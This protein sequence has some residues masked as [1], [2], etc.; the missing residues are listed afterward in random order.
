MDIETAMKIVKE[1]GKILDENPVHNIQG[2]RALLLPYDKDT[3]K[4]ALKVNLT[5]VGTAEKRDKKTFRS[6]K[7]GF[8]QLASFLPDGVV[9][10]MFHVEDALDSGDVCHK[11][12]KYLAESEKAGNLILEQTAKLVEELDEFCQD[13]GL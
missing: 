9:V 11:Y 3:I 6:L 10:P 2:R 8:L 5:Y 13:N 4:E 12:Y 1:Y 7:L